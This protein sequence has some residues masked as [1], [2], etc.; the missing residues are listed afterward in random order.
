MNSVCINFRIGIRC[1]YDSI[2]FLLLLLTLLLIIIIII[3]II[4]TIIIII[5][6]I[7]PLD[8]NWHTGRKDYSISLSPSFQL[9]F[10]T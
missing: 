6:I 2:F 10:R 9:R 7:Y 3:I 5:I 4:I 1:Y 8:T